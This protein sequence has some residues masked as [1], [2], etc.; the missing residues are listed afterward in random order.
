MAVQQYCEEN[1]C[2]KEEVETV[3]MKHNIKVI[4]EM[5]YTLSRQQRRNLEREYKGKPY[6]DVK[7]NF[8]ASYTS[9]GE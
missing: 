1:C 7:F 6:G 5:V 9:P 8:R 2:R 3:L 4:N